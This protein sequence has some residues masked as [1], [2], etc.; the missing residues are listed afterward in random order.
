MYYLYTLKKGGNKMESSQ[1]LDFQSSKEKNI[2]RGKPYTPEGL[3]LKVRQIQD[4]AFNLKPENNN[5]IYLRGRYTKKGEKYSEKSKCYYHFLQGVSGQKIKIEIQENRIKEFKGYEEDILTIQGC[6]RLSYDNNGNAY[7]ILRFIQIIDSEVDNSNL[8]EE[9]KILKLISKNTESIQRKKINFERNMFEKINL[10]EQLKILFLL[11]ISGYDSKSDILDNIDSRYSNWIK[12]QVDDVNIQNKQS[13]LKKI[14][15]IKKSSI[16]DYKIESNLQEIVKH[17]NLNPDTLVENC[18]DLIVIAR[19]G[20]DDLSVFDD[21]EIVENL[22]KLKTPL[23]V[24]IGHHKDVTYTD[25]ISARACSVPKDV[26]I[27]I[28]DLCENFEEKINLLEEKEIKDDEIKNL[29][30]QL[31]NIEGEKKQYKDKWEIAIKNNEE[32]KNMLEKN[33]KLQNELIAKKAEIEKFENVIIQL[34]LE[35]GKMEK[36]EKNIVKL[37]EEYYH[38]M[39]ELEKKITNT[40]NHFKEEVEKIKINSK[41]DGLKKAIALGVI[42]LTSIVVLSIGILL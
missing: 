35:K 13:I 1:L 40:E 10:N 18:F 38:K 8:I 16:K 3:I 6:F 27:L 9:I 2:P 15:Q 39:R 29:K 12:Y 42:V 23:V 4:E 19:G 25:V 36:D 24:A 17:E 41:K 11:P 28:N 14:D 31:K 20:G 21:Y 34:K 33:E 30:D 5:T 26:A 7:S 22:L 32:G 37:T